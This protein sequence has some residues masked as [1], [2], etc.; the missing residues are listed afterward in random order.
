M[1]GQ[2]NASFLLLPYFYG[3]LIALSLVTMADQK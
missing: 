2:I 1:A 3:E